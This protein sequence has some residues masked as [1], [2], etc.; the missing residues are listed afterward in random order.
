MK[1]ILAV[2]LCIALIIT[3]LP[4]SVLDVSAATSGITGDCTWTLDGT[5]LTIR[6]NGAM[7]NYS[8]STSAPWET[9]I[10]EVIIENGVTSIGNMAFYYCDSLMSITI[11][12]SVTSIGDNAFYYCESLTS[13]TIPNSVKSIGSSAFSSCILLISISVGDSV[14]SVGNYAFS[15]TAWYNN[16][17]DGLI[18][19]GKVA[20][21]YK[22][23]CPSSIVIEA[24]TLSIAGVAFYR[25][26]SLISITIPKGVKNIG[27][28]AFEY[29]SSLRSVY[30]GGSIADKIK[31]SVSSNNSDFKNAMWYYDS[32]IGVA[33]HTYNNDCDAYCNVCD[34]ERK[35]SYHSYDEN[36][37]C[38]TCGRFK[39]IGDLDD[40]GSV[41]TTDL[42]IMKLFLAG[43]G[44]L[45]DTGKLGGD[46]SGDGK[47]DTTD[48]AMLK[49]KLAGNE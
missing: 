26:T 10:T 25:C 27:G 31:L 39:Y 15:N 7:G 5:I 32:C 43:A 33:E 16:Q 9:G 19:I 13:V 34:F 2:I 1:K 48:L 37:I 24:G 36:E 45:S 30:F 46:L 11:P 38:R 8:P 40:N 42:A 4:L 35:V 41:D 12:N 6:G 44:E 18:Y 28:G 21:S 17:P 22:G 29:C 14:S 23:V 20:Y 3:A 49:L 47:V